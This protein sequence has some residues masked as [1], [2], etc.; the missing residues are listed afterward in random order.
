MSLY[1]IQRLIFVAKH[2]QVNPQKQRLSD[3]RWACRQR[4]VTA[5]CLTFR[6]LL[7]TLDEIVNGDDC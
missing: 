1:L 5:I 6:A 4:S 3:T 7:A 2:L